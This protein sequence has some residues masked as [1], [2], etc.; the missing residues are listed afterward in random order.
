MNQPVQGQLIAENRRFAIVVSRF[1]EMITRRLLDGALDCL[2]R[3]KAQ[4]KDI[5]VVWV[6]GSFEIPTVALKLAQ[7]KRHDA[8]ICLA[9]VI[10]GGTDHYQH[11]AAEVTKGIA[12]VGLQTGVPTIFGVLTCETLEEAL[13]RAGAK[14]GNKGWQAALSGIEMADLM[15]RLDR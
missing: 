9:A 10:R 11:V 6:P 3:H 4:E 12:Q 13:E 7:S 14:Q 2:L 15:G 5:T 8:V 1:N